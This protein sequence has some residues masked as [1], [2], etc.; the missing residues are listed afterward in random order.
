MYAGIEVGSKG[1]KMSIVEIG[2]NA[3]KDGTFN[4]LKDTSVNT[5]FISFSKSA[6]DNTL[7][8]FG[9]V[10]YCR[11]DTVWRLLPGMCLL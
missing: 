4:I 5:D 1:V 2:K 10:I 3:R 6:S 11:V 9:W 8:K 7:N